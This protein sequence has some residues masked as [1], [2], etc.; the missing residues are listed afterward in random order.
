VRTTGRQKYPC[1]SRYATGVSAEFRSESQL[2]HSS[3]EVQRHWLSWSLER[4]KTFNAAGYQALPAA[5]LQ[6]AGDLALQA[7]KK[8]LIGA[9]AACV[10]L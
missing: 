8:G 4:M 1:R 10:L 6:P 9:I 2:S 3:L 5:T 7:V